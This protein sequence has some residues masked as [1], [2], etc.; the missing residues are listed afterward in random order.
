MHTLNSEPHT[1]NPEPQAETLAAIFL[2]VLMGLNPRPQAL[3]FKTSTL[4]LSVLIPR[5]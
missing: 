4:N 2:A 1:L 3:A 5:V